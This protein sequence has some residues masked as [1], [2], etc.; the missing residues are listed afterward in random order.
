M[1]ISFPVNSQ[2]IELFV[3]NSDFFFFCAAQYQFFFFF[4][5]KIFSLK[6]SFKQKMRIVILGLLVPVNNKIY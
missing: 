6:K 1:W 4:F 3:N 5:Y 2:L